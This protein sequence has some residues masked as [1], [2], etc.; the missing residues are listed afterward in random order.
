MSDWASNEGGRM[1]LVVLD[2]DPQGN[3]AAVLQI[4]PNPGWTTYWREPGDSG[5][6]PA[7]S[8]APGSPFSLAALSFA[9]PKRLDSGDVRDIGYDAAVSLP[10]VL[11]GPVPQEAMALDA[12]VFIGLCRNICIPFQA[13]L[14]VTLSPDAEASAEERAILTDA[15]A[16]LPESPSADFA[17]SSFAMAE[18]LK[19]LRL[20]LVLPKGAGDRPQ[21][22]ATGPNGYVFTDYTATSAADGRLTVDLPIAKLPRHYSIAGKAWQVLVISGARAMESPLAFD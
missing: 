2:A 7:I 5:I 22:M 14:A 15:R 10:M 4:E 19:N 16:R 12:T 17:V 6:P 18:D 21:I 13:D 8:F 11:T 9:V 20:E 1:R 3:R